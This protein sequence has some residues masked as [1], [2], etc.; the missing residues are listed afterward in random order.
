MIETPSGF[1][2]LLS[3]CELNLNC[4]LYLTYF[5]GSDLFEYHI[6]VFKFNLW[7]GAA[8][9]THVLEAVAIVGWW[10]SIGSIH[11]CPHSTSAGG[12]LVFAFTSLAYNLMV[13]LIA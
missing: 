10:V 4:P 1:R 8:D 2:F 9:T 13:M 12:K 6:I 3:R 11:W 7:E 5:I